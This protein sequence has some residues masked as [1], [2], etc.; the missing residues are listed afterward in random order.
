MFQVK[1]GAERQATASRLLL[2]APSVV[3]LKCCKIISCMVVAIVP[4]T[5]F[6]PFVFFSKKVKISVFCILKTCIFALPK[7][8]LTENKSK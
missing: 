8:G 4:T 2:D 5:L 3:C 6:Q 1:S 7:K